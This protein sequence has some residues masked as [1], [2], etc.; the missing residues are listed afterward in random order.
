MRVYLDTSVIV[1]VL[2]GEPD[3]LSSWGRW[4]NAYTSR[5]WHVEALRVLDRA[6]IKT[7]CS[8]ETLI[9]LRRNIDVVHSCLEIVPASETIL[10]RAGESFPTIIGTLDAIHLATALHV[11]ESVALDVFLTHDR[12]LGNA[13]AAMGFIV[14]GV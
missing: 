14:E 4:Q 2:F 5:L 6:R 10:L 9:Q 12:Q 7:R 13:A 1:R 3:P 11:R 8:T